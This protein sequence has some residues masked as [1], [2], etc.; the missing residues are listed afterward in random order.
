[1]KCQNGMEWNWILIPAKSNIMPQTEC[2]MKYHMSKRLKMQE[3]ELRSGLQLNQYL[4][5]KLKKQ[6][7]GSGFYSEMI[8]M[9]LRRIFNLSAWAAGKMAWVI[10]YLLARDEEGSRSN[11]VVRSLCD[12]A[13]DFLMKE[14][15][16]Q[17][18][19]SPVTICG[20]ILGQ[21]HDI[22]EFF[23]I[24]GK[25][26]IQIALLVIATV[27]GYSTI[28]TQPVRSMGQP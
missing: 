25:V 10:L 22:A 17:P 3:P 1:M 24:G 23:R 2:Q 19:K 8:E 21:F 11:N 26:G 4:A 9:E 12:Q 20:D 27:C 16:V 5:L 13:K 28:Q 18:V 15:N 14:S 7:R 6:E